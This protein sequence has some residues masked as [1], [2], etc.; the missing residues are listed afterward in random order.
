[1]LP[2]SSMVMKSHFS[3]YAFLNVWKCLLFTADG[4]ADAQLIDS[5]MLSLVNEQFLRM[6]PWFQNS[7]QLTASQMWCF[8]QETLEKLFRF[9]SFVYAQ[10]TSKSKSARFCLLHM[11]NTS[12]S[13]FGKF[14]YKSF[15][16]SQ[17]KSERTL[18]FFFFFRE[19]QNLALWEAICI[20]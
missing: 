6:A 13:G 1:M 19:R 7:I 5:T 17:E 4:F 14:W 9:M 12:K 8:L 11:C 3:W 20:S 2:F 10:S 16:Y 15:G 18:F